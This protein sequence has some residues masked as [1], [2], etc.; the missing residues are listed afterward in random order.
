[1]HRKSPNQWSAYGKPS[2]HWIILAPSVMMSNEAA[3]CFQWASWADVIT[4]GCVALSIQNQSGR[5]AFSV[6]CNFPTDNDGMRYW[7][8][9]VLCCEVWKCGLWTQQEIYAWDVQCANFK[10]VSTLKSWKNRT[11]SLGTATWTFDQL[12]G[13][14]DRSWMQFI[15][16]LLDGSQGWKLIIT[17]LKGRFIF[18]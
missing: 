12:S 5:W 18:W 8:L 6:T 16:C 13:I 14:P 7:D 15:L 2:T 4:Q 11:I 9:P 3:W 17:F 10:K 1:M